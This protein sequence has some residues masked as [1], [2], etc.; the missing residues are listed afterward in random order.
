[1]TS[2][3]IA[4]MHLHSMGS[5]WDAFPARDVD[6]GAI[7]LK[8]VE[9]YVRLAN[10]TGGRKIEDEKPLEVLKKLKLIREGKPTWASIL[11]FGKESST[12]ILLSPVH[13]GRFRSDKTQIIDDLMVEENLI[14]QVEDVMKFITRHISVRYEFEGK[15]RRREIW[16]YPLDALREAVI[17]AIV[18][19][20]YTF[21][22]NVQVEIYDDDV[23][24]WSPGKLPLGI[25]I[26]DLYKKP[27]DSVLRNK[28]IAQIFFD[29]GY[30]ER[31]GT[32]T[33]KIMELCKEHG[34]PSPEFREDSGGFSV[35][36]RKDIYTEEYLESLGLNE[37]QIKAVMYVKEKGRITNKEYVK[38]NGITRETAKRDLS[39]L[40]DKGILKVVG[41]GRGIY[42][43]I[44]S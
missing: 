26:Q 12:P 7:D 22:A 40:V 20:D 28:L 37:R 35:I 6:A 14:K 29:I 43:V 5:S 25:T 9:N 31:Y 23:R 34:I 21:P 38:I 3:E 15:P 2:Q 30:I 18:H 39:D 32:G 33:T 19:R 11:L 1:M 4:E 13:C 44:G 41:K 27:H 16:E 17:N 24:I 10:A 42:Y 8:R 36:F